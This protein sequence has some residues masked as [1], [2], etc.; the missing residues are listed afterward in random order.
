[1]TIH[2]RKIDIDSCGRE[3]GQPPLW[4]KITARVN[5]VEVQFTVGD[6]D[7]ALLIDAARPIVARLAGQVSDAIGRTVVEL[8][9]PKEPAA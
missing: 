7:A 8:R 9:K 1:V 2:I 6:T 3:D 4:A 5:G